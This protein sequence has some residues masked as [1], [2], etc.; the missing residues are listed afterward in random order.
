MPCIYS[1]IHIISPPITLHLLYHCIITLLVMCQ[2]CTS[3]DCELQTHSFYLQYLPQCLGITDVTK[4][5]VKL[6]LLQPTVNLSTD[7]ILPQACFCA[8]RIWLLL[9]YLLDIRLLSEALYDACVYS[10]LLSA[11][12]WGKFCSWY[13]KMDWV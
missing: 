8:F 4:M 9:Y 3:K 2:Q 11:S 12:L 1:H 5:L 7:E 6:V 13:N 10:F